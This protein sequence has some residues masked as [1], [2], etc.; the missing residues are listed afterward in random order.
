[1][2]T[3]AKIG[4]CVG[5]KGELKLHLVTDF[6]EQFRKGKTFASDKL[7]LTIEYYNDNRGIVK[8][9]G[10]DDRTSA[11]KLTT[12][13]LYTTEEDT[14][15]NCNLNQDEYYYFDVIGCEIVDN[16]TLLGKVTG[17]QEISGTNYF[18]IDTDSTLIDKGF[19]KH[20]MLPYID[21]YIVDVDITTKKITAKDAIGI[22]EAS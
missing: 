11:E 21:N 15:D 1:M 18:E 7:Q 16:D 6:P 9:V 2:F 10:Y 13:Q 22:L 19:A 14:R 3:I 8:F 20:F 5:L 17:I 4:K 12:R